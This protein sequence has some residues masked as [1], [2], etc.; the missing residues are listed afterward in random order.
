[1]TFAILG[2]FNCLNCNL[3]GSNVQGKNRL[4]AKPTFPA[5][6]YRPYFSCGKYSTWLFLYIKIG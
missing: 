6:K 5:E 2:Y 3:H 1:M 4:P